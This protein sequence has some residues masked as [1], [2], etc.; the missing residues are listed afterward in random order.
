MSH[1]EVRSLFC[2]VFSWPE[3]G[4]EVV[5]TV[6]LIMHSGSSCVFV[7]YS[8]VDIFGSVLLRIFIMRV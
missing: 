3:G 4:E 2:I 1:V 7:E 5:L 8:R 6:C